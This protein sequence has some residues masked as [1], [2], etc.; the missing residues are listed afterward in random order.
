MTATSPTV[1]LKHLL[2]FHE[3]HG[4]AGTIASANILRVPFASVESRKASRDGSS[5]EASNASLFKR[6][7]LSGRR[8]GGAGSGRTRYDIP[9]SSRGPRPMARQTCVFSDRRYWM[10]HRRMDYFERPIRN[11][12]GHF[13]RAGR[14]RGS[15]VAPSSPIIPALR[16]VLEGVTRKNLPRRRRQSA[17][18]LDGSKRARGGANAIAG[19]VLR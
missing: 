10:D 14:S 15:T 2:D 5:R 7:H 6:R 12:S 19:A 4:A 1:D 16:G 3:E 13:T 8:G 18:L 9:S 17:H 11:Y